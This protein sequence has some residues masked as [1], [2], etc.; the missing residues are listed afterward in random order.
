[1]IKIV[2]D[3]LEYLHRG[4][5]I[6][7][8]QRWVGT[9]PRVKPLLEVAHGVVEPFEQVRTARR[10]LARMVESTVDYLGADDRPWIA[11]MHS[12]S[13]EAAAQLHEMLQVHYPGA[14]YFSAEIGPIVGVHIG[15]GGSGIMV[16]PSRVVNL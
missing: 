15:P 7:T 16:C 12:R 5:R 9:L 4:G 1:M 3:T 14:R 13:P 2:S 6:N 10:A 11:V 8:A